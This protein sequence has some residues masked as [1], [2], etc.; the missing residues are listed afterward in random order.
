MIGMSASRSSNLSVVALGALVTAVAFALF[1][2]GARSASEPSG[3]IAFTRHDGIYVMR[4]DGTGV[5]P[6]R[7]DGAAASALGLAWSPDGRKLAFVSKDSLWT[8][9]A[10]GTDIVRLVTTQPG[11][12]P[13]SPTWSP[14]GR[15]VAYTT[16]GQGK[17]LV[18]VV[19]ADGSK[20]RLL[21]KRL[22]LRLYGGSEIDWSP[23]GHRVALT[24]G[25]WVSDLYV[26]NT[27]GSQPRKLL[28][29]VPGSAAYQ[30]HWSPDG[31]RIVLTH[32]YGAYEV[33]I[34]VTD[35]DGRTGVRILTSDGFLDSD[36]TWSSD[37][38]RI[39][40][41]RSDKPMCL[42][43]PPARRGSAEIYVMNADG[44]GVARLTHNQV[45]EGS[46]AW[47]QVAPS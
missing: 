16:L 22:R 27:D 38:S 39:A 44:T 45:G 12:A 11:R 20:R 5:R 33:D 26:M 1:V 43:C 41:A 10:D 15:R 28:S 42:W 2:G 7:R 3:L 25:G 30:P 37:G 31:R 13:L 35:G 21:T 36:P 8:M 6:L 47:Q 46:P 40:F 17:S 24:T 34:A 32:T 4:A 14:D 19:N 29:S 23:S 18:W 9:S